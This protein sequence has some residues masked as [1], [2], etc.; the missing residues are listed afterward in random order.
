MKR[1]LDQE[2]GY[3]SSEPSDDID[4]DPVDQRRKLE[5][6]KKLEERMEKRR[7]KEELEDY[8]GELD[9]EFDW[10]DSDK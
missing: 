6:K 9:D 5:I 7:L 3:A 2:E 4:F 10:G 1:F 8:D